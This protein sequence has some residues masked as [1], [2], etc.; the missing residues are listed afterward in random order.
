MEDYVR[1]WIINN[2]IGWI[3]L[4]FALF[5]VV[6]ELCSNGSAIKNVL[7]NVFKWLKE[8]VIFRLRLARRRHFNK[9]LSSEDFLT[10]QLYVLRRLYFR[11]ENI[12]GFEL[13]KLKFGN[14][15]QEYEAAIWSPTHV[16][17][18]PF[19]SIWDK[20]KLVYM[21]DPQFKKID[22]YI[23]DDLSSDL[24]KMVRKYEKIIRAT[25]HSP[26]K[27]GYMMDKIVILDEQLV[28]VRTRVGNYYQNILQSH[29]LEYELY[30]LYKKTV[31]FSIRKKDGN[32]I[33]KKVEQMSDGELWDSLPLRRKIHIQCNETEFIDGSGRASLM[34]VQIMVLIKNINGKYDC[35]RIR[36][37]ENVA[38]KAG[39]LQFVPSGGFEAF[40]DGDSIDI[41]R[42]NYSINKVLFRE[43]GEECF[44]LSES[45]DFIRK[46]VEIIYENEYIKAILKLIKQGKAQYE[47]IGIAESLAGL[48]PEFCFL[49]VIKDPTIASHIVCN[50]E[51]DSTITLIDIVEME[52]PEFWNAD[53]RKKLN[54]T[55]AA[56]WQLARKTELY[57]SCLNATK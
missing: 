4:P 30:M 48:R 49:L 47:F 20:N 40:N 5:C 10:W 50:S 28:E 55:S 17:K 41:Q 21:Q 51:T 37:S 39:F 9:Q 44:G 22:D 23:Q 16:I 36:R 14:D 46:P 6:A 56:L 29:V 54:C 26:N 31:S 7:L 52:K 18:Y 43:L 12:N 2:G 35:L 45:K 57:Q 8:N 13:C 1:G 38:A 53:D 27:I 19:S 15:V 42:S 24:H 3:V 11:E 33:L 25:V 34:S 32:G